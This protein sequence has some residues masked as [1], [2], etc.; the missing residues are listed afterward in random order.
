LTNNSRLEG[1]T[2]GTDLAD[3]LFGDGLD[4]QTGRLIVW[5]VHH[6]Q[7]SRVLMY[8][9]ARGLEFDKERL[10]KKARNLRHHW[11]VDAARFEGARCPLCCDYL[12][13]DEEN[14]CECYLRAVPGVYIEPTLLAIEQEKLSFPNNWQT[15]LQSTYICSNS[16]CMRLNDLALGVVASDLR[17][18]QI[19]YNQQLVEYNLALSHG[20]MR[21]VRPKEPVWRPKTKCHS[22]YM[23]DQKGGRRSSAPPPSRISDRPREGITLASL[24]QTLPP[25]AES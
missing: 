4:L 7:I 5:G 21:A 18:L 6:Q 8:L 16:H 3:P 19:R 10:Y 20:D 14:L 22:C 13:E 11:M 24:I 17:K 1:E 9:R 23:Q 2:T 12:P 15:R 25:T